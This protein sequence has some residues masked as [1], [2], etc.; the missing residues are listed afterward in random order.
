MN[1]WFLLLL[2]V[3]ASVA[4]ADDYRLTNPGPGGGSDLWTLVFHPTDADTFYIG[5]DIEGPFKTTDGGLSY[6]RVATGLQLSS[7]PAGANA[8]QDFGIDPGNP[9]TVFLATWA[10]IYKTTDGAANW[11]LVYPAPPLFGEDAES[12]SAV[13]V[14]PHSSNIVLAGNGNPFANTGLST[15]VR[16][17]DGGSTFAKI[18][19]TAGDLLSGSGNAVHRIVFDP[20]LAG[21]VYAATSEGVLKSQDDGLTWSMASTGL[22]EKPIA[23]G[24][25]GVVTDGKLLLFATLRTPTADKWER[26]GVYRSMDSGATWEDITGDLPTFGAE[27][28]MA[29]SYWR[30]AV[31]P[32][33]PNNLIVGTRR[34]YAWD[35]MG[36]YKTSIALTTDPGDVKWT[37]LWDNSRLDEVVKEWGWLDPAWWNDLHVHFIGYSPLIKDLV[38]TGSVNVFR[39]EDNGATW[40]ERYSINNGDGTFSSRGLELMEIFDLSVDPSSPDTWWLGADDMGLFKS[41]DAGRSFRRMDASQNADA[42]N[43]TD[44]A[45]QVVVDPDD[46][47]ILY[48]VRHGGDSEG[49]QNWRRGY[50]YKS[51]DA[52]QSW[53]QLGPGMIEGGR[54]D[55]VMLR[56]GTSATRTLVVSIYGKGLFRSTDAGASWAEVNAGIDQAD[57]SYVWGIVESQ[58]AEGR[59]LL[60]TANR[61][62][63]GTGY[64]G[65]IYLSSDAGDSWQKVTAATAP[66]GQILDLVQAS[67]GVMYAAT[68]AFDGW[69]ATGSGTSAG[70]LY[71]S[72][73]EGQ[74]WTRV[75]S[76]PRVEG[77]AVHASQP[78]RVAA[79]AS[80]NWNMLE[81]GDHDTVQPGLYVSTDNGLQFTRHTN[82][83]TFNFFWF[84]KSDPG[85]PGRFFLGSRGGGLF[86]ASPATSATQYLMTNSSSRNVT[87]LH[88]VNS[89]NAEQRFSGTLY[90]GDGNV[91]GNADTQLHSGAIAPAGRVILKAA[92]IESLVGTEPWTGPAMLNVKVEGRFSLMSKLV[93]PSGLISNTNCVRDNAVM[94]VEGFDSANRTFVR[95]INNS[96]NAIGAVTGTLY[97]ESGAVVG[98]A[99]TELLGSLNA[100]Q[101]V[102]ISRDDLATLVGSQWNGTAMLMVEAEK[103][104]KLLNL[105]FV[106]EETFFNFSCFESADSG[107]VYLMTNS[108]SRNVSFLHLVNTADKEQTFTG[109]IHDQAGVQLGEAGVDLGTVNARGRLVISAQ[110]LEGLFGV[111]AWSGPA[112]LTVSGSAGGEFELMVK[113]TSPSGLISNTNCVR[114]GEV[115][116]IEGQDSQDETFVRLINTGESELTNITGTLYRSDGS[117]IG[118][119]QTQLVS[120][121]E[122]HEAVWVSRSELT[123]MFG[124]TW[125]GEA[126]LKVDGP[127]S[128]KLLNL[129]FANRETFF[130]FSCYEEAQ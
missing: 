86:A 9:G 31:D 98:K 47:N 40:D 12:F 20:L 106:N 105:N 29:Y 5:G 110:Q 15:I 116:N 104:L 76:Q 121:L 60:G 75:L 30:I 124:D 78:T 52:G 46:G 62:P 8:S 35:Q 93:S 90:S 63:S 73:D 88:I 79:L 96:D 18:D 100:R 39:S 129:N 21:V 109:S 53:Q 126:T 64:Q 16:S 7:F 57:L 42:F 2:L 37:W 26:S 10:G 70:G 83:L 123:S 107:Q 24:L 97:D 36:I 13:A 99:G 61:S 19:L 82:G 77:V 120:S 11:S 59:L 92:D 127:A 130:N 49:Q 27:S 4:A 125:S 3:A 103:G 38:Y 69:L 55:L 14:S 80:T 45:C 72:A 32:N 50:L 6:Q 113:L 48:V 58:S 85:T 112:L 28:G 67:N 65:R 54:P 87:N 17:T 81:S 89:S 91:L 101:A 23:H 119:A 94:N 43:S 114:T 117:V 122:P 108:A 51:F 34:E 41:V 68:T 95:F 111:A 74:T 56:G 84:L 33:N 1:H 118:S 115:H 71:R 128:L 25:V 66:T 44:C 102:W 22:P